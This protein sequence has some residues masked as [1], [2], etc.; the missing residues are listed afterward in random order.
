MTPQAAYDEL[1]RRSRE[2]TLLASCS[3]LLGWDEQTY[4]PRGGAAHRGNQMALLAGLHHEKATDPRIGELLERLEG[5]DLVRDPEVAAA[6]NVREIRR[7]YDRQTK[8][9]RTLVEELARTTTL[10]QQEWVAARQKN[11]FA[12]LPALAGKDR[13]PEAARGRVPRASGDGRL[14][15]PARRV[16]AGRHQRRD[17]RGSSR[18]CGASWCRW[19]RRSWRAGSAPDPAVLRHATG[20]PV[21]RQRIFGEAVAAAIGFDFQRGRLDTTAHPFCTGIGP[22]D[23]RITTRYEPDDFSDAFFGI[24]HE[25]GHGLYEQGLDPEHYGTPMGE[26]VSLGIHE[27]QSRLWENAVGRSRPFW[28]H[29][30]PAG[31]ADLPR[32]AGRRRASTTSTSPS[33]TSSRRLIRVQADEVTYNLH[34]LLRFELEQALLTGDLPVGDVPAAW[35]EAMRAAPRPDAPQ[36]RRGL[37]PGHPLERRPVR[38]LPDLHPGQPLRR[39]AL[40][41]APRPSSATS[42]PPFARGDFAALLA[43]LR[44]KVHRQGRRYRPARLIEHATGTPPDPQPL[45]DALRT[46]YGE[47]YQF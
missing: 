12:P 27:S 24:L 19:S 46:K 10:A 31:P 29:C 9:P 40:R 37:P 28:T 15:R 8:L 25:V 33:T 44:A 32:G 3:A 23:C 22:G 7:S 20:Y 2:Q 36:R 6:V 47:L 21:D 13:P 5:S 14:R 45:I 39:P 35:N 18:R 30:L 11:D 4:M 42:T 26:A 1:I 38:L 41:R 43:W 16:R 34:I 17:S